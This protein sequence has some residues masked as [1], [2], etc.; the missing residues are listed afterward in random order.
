[1]KT[2]Y[3]LFGFTPLFVVAC[4]T[5]NPSNVVSFADLHADPN[6]YYE[7]NVCATG[8][9]HFDR[10]SAE[11]IPTADGAP[12]GAKKVSLLDFDR[13]G[14]VDRRTGDYRQG[15]AIKACG[16]VDFDRRC[17]AKVNPLTCVPQSIA[18]KN[19]TVEKI[20]SDS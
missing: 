18:I 4:A 15:T 16:L 10:N 1:M 9:L 14:F 3:S 13:S 19:A 11:L 5:P 6:R 7:N 2:F 20:T 8:Y 12:Q 17:F